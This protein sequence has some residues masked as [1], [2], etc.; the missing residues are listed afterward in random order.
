M[1]AIK[2]TLS[3][4][5]DKT[6]WRSVVQDTLEHSVYA[7]GSTGY[8]HSVRSAISALAIK[9]PNWDAYTIIHTNVKK[10]VQK[11]KLLLKL[12]IIDNQDEWDDPW[13]RYQRII[14]YEQKLCEEV[15][16]YLRN[17]TG[18]RRMLLLGS[19]TTH[20]GTQGNLPGVNLC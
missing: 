6:D 14:D 20:S 7:K 4:I 2:D 12:W 17:L 13:S 3:S 16:D 11:H 1:S 18:T 8:K 9:F 10:I 15:D 5:L 19:K